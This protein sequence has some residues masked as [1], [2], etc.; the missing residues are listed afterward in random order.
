MARRLVAPLLIAFFLFSAFAQA[1][2]HKRT[3]AGPVV[4]E[5]RKIFERETPAIVTVYSVDSAGKR[6]AMGSG[7]IVRSNGVV[8]TNYHVVQGAA[9]AQIKL[10]NDEIYENVLVRDY[11]KRH[12]VVVLQIRGLNLATVTLGDSATVGLGDRVYAIGHPEGYDYTI[13]DGLVS[14]RRVEN[15]T[16]MLQISVPISH[17]SSGGPLYNTYGQVIG[18]TTAGVEGAQNLN[19][20]VPLKYVL[21]ML[22]AMPRNISLAQLPG[23]A[24]AQQPAP[25]VQQPAPPPK[26]A[27]R[28]RT[29]VDPKGWLEL[30]APPGWK[31]DD[32]PP[33]G[34]MLL[35][36]KEDEAFLSAY[37]S[38][39]R[40][41]DEAFQA[42]KK[43]AIK[44]FGKLK[45]ISELVKLD[46]EGER[47][48]RMQTFEIKS[49][50][51]KIMFLGA[52]QH[53][54]R[55]VGMLGIVT[56]K[57]ALSELVDGL[58]SIVY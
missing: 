4:M 18:I 30:T 22:D 15:G 19:F 12:D 35:M 28:S 48:A 6:I 51:G 32:S 49:G 14:A 3:P 42:A 36:T 44:Q 31:I 37:H 57:G 29:F 20:A 53:G 54:Q 26:Q 10:K 11:D 1:Q 9:D 13:T 23:E 8:V 56:T 33:E 52:F 25:Q 38:D 58:S 39:S 50:N 7:F 16:E 2:T 55:V 24:P 34:T 40:S 45:D 5:P 47:H 17:G 21:P 46:Q 43:V 41:A 27:A